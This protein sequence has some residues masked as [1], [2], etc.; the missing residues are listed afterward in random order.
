MT[1]RYKWDVAEKLGE[2]LCEP[3][4]DFEPLIDKI[5][6]GQALTAHFQP[7]FSS[8]DGRVFGCEALARVAPQFAPHGIGPLFSSARKQGLVAPLDRLCRQAALEC[9]MQ[10]G[11]AA[12]SERLFINVC[13]ETLM[14]GGG[15]PVMELIER[16]GLPRDRVIFEVTEESAVQDYDLFARAITFYRDLGFQIAIDDFG[17]GYGGLKMLA[18][19]EPEYVKID[20]HFTQDIERAIVRRN[21]VDSIATVCH[22]L[23]I[24]VVAEGIENDADAGVLI[25]MGVEFLQGFGLARPAAKWPEP[26]VCVALPR[27]SCPVVKSVE[28][29]FIGD[30]ARPTPTLATTALMPEARRLFIDNPSLMSLAILDGERCTGMLHRGSFFE[31]QLSGPFG[32]GTALSTYRSVQELSNHAAFVVVEANQTLED[33]SHSL[34][35][36]HLDSRSD[37]I[38]IT[39]NGKY[40]GTVAVSALLDAMT[41]RSLILARGA[42]PL[43]GLPGN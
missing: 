37:D 25:E 35:H 30:I 18:V 33:V 21:L 27:A 1:T 19:I 9:A 31:Q 4:L 7:I 43:S 23:G 29:T 34:R 32:Y 24:K 15:E 10:Q 20:R 5:I 26:G 13:P 41:Q 2:E 28:H 14:D 8:R 22:R 6:E 38:C 39:S 16:L 36:R 12:R 11:F 42:N 40:R 17:V 3:A